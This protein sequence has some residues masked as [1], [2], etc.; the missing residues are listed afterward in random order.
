MFLEKKKKDHNIWE[1]TV[2]VQGSEKTCLRPLTQTKPFMGTKS[3][4]FAV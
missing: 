1:E 2:M 4:P 3:S